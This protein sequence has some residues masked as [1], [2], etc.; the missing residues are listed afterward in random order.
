MDRKKELA[1]YFGPQ[2]DSDEDL[3]EDTRKKLQD[4]GPVAAEETRQAAWEKQDMYPK[5]KR[6]LKG[7]WY[8]DKRKKE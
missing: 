4:Q 6:S 2:Y 8:G 7:A 5:L 1:N 3:P